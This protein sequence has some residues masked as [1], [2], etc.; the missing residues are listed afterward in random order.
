MSPGQRCGRADVLTKIAMATSFSWMCS[1]MQ[2][3][4]LLCSACRTASRVMTAFLA[5][6]RAA[7]RQVVCCGAAGARKCG[8]SCCQ[9]VC[10]TCI[11]TVRCCDNICSRCSRGLRTA[12]SGCLGLLCCRQC[13]L[14]SDAC[15]ACV[16]GVRGCC[17][18]GV[19]GLFC[20]GGLMCGAHGFVPVCG[21]VCGDVEEQEYLSLRPNHADSDG[22]DEEPLAQRPRLSEDEAR[23]ALVYT[24]KGSINDNL[25]AASGVYEMEAFDVDRDRVALAWRRSVKRHLGSQAL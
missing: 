3:A 20:C 17:T 22:E 15:G 1:A 16:V 8:Q 10:C 9:Y 2:V 18:Y 25:V 5:G 6:N 23:A 4:P 14:C 11:G 12:V 7:T 19:G 21:T 13:K 24:A